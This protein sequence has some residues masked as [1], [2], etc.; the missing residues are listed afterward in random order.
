MSGVRK[1]KKGSYAEVLKVRRN[2][3]EEAMWL[4]IG[5]KEVMHRKELLSRCLVGPQESLPGW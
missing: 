2:G 5:E 3:P 4:H 1:Q